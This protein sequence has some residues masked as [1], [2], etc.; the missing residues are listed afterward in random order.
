MASQ[1][2]DPVR[3]TLGLLTVSDGAA[4]S[5]TRSEAAAAVA[6]AAEKLGWKVEV[7]ASVAEDERQI[8]AS[9]VDLC[10]ENRVD[11]VLTLGGQGLGPRDVTPEATRQVLEKELPGLPELMRLKCMAKTPAAALSRGVAG[12]RRRTLILNLPGRPKAALESFHAVAGLLPHAV[13]MLR[14]AAPSVSP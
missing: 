7:S 5:G 1:R 9:L 8:R 12:T 13:G 11:L 3:L 10:V 14:E 2:P 6:L 4:P